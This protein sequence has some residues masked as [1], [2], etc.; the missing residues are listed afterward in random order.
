MSQ[1]TQTVGVRLRSF[2]LQRG[3]SQ[4]RLAELAGLHPTYIGQIERGE[5]N[6][7]LESLC[8]VTQALSISMS[9]L[10]ELAD[11]APAPA[12]ES[13]PLRAY[14]LLSSLPTSR[15]EALYQ[16]LASVARYGEG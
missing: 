14:N 7:T 10:L 6:L 5:K 13:Y 4:E 8:K 1:I 12:P 9:Q 3:Y 16:I 11:G 15:Q 2:R